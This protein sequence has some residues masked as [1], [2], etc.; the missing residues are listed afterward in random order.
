MVWGGSWAIRRDTFEQSACARPGRARSA[1]TWWPTSA[2]PGETTGPL[3]SGLRGD[4]AA[5]LR[6]PETLAFIRRQYLITRHYAHF[7]WLVAVLSSTLR[8]V[9]L[10]GT[11]AALGRGLLYGT[12]AP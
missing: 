1:T 5:G 9:V 7:W 12:P 6:C 11:L 10:L 8:N 2:S 4:V 3:P